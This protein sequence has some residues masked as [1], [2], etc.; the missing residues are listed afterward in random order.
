MGLYNDSNYGF[1]Q[2]NGLF[3]KA[4]L[5]SRSDD[6]KFFKNYFN[7]TFFDLTIITAEFVQII[8]DSNQSALSQLNITGDFEPIN[9]GA[10]QWMD[11]RVAKDSILTL[12][13]TVPGYVEFGAYLKKFKNTS[14]TLN[15]S[16]I[17]N[18]LQFNEYNPIKTFVSDNRLSYLIKNKN[19]DKFHFN[20]HFETIYVDDSLSLL[21]KY[22]M[23]RIFDSSNPVEFI[24]NSLKINNIIESKN[25]FDYLNYLV[26]NVAFQTQ[27]NGTKALTGLSQLMS[28]VFYH[29]IDTMST[30]LFNKILSINVF[31]AA[32]NNKNCSDV[33]NN[34]F[35]SISFNQ[36]C[37]NSLLNTS[38][39]NNIYTWIDGIFN[40]N[41]NLQTLTN[42]TDIQMTVLRDPTSNFLVLI[43]SQIEQI[44]IK[45]NLSGNNHALNLFPLGFL[46]WLSGNVTK[47]L[48]PDSYQKNSTL[49]LIPNLFNGNEINYIS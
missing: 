43:N 42:L 25:I 38:N 19:L 16:Q 26:D 27:L 49:E 9:L 20:K 18:L 24:N 4:L 14:T 36:I 29:F 8:K 5:N 37:N 7:L 23:D 30:S 32:F 45:Y 22:N 3:Y 47:Q 33:L 40:S 34:W 44:K 28:Q 2:K 1:S 17:K 13:S 10:Y 21:N 35:P 12:N 39:L 46:Q 31:E 15:I 6:W 48:Q 41:V 11:F